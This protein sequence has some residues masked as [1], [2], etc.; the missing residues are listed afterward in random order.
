MVDLVENKPFT[1]L[2]FLRFYKEKISN[3][4]RTETKPQNSC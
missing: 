4:F 1:E 2:E 3:R